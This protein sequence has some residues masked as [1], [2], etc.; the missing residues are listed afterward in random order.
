VSIPTNA[1]TI[2]KT[3]PISPLT[4][5]AGAP[6][7]QWGYRNRNRVPPLAVTQASKAVADMVANRHD[8]I[9]VHKPTYRD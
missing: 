2:H 9:S 1:K 4:Q 8:H 3:R 7:V 5:S 6:L